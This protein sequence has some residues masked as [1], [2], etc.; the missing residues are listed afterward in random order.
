MLGKHIKTLRM[1][2]EISTQR[3][4]EYMRIE[5][6][7]LRD[8]EAGIRVPDEKQLQRLSKLFQVDV[9]EL[10]GMQ[11]QTVEKKQRQP[12]TSDKKNKKQKAKKEK[13][14]RKP[15][16]KQSIKPII[17]RRSKPLSKSAEYGRCF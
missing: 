3:L 8:W 17:R 9:S 13:P 16:E 4:A 11:K 1:E 15:D 5:E 7:E 12:N 10:C 14:K 6:E 2:Y